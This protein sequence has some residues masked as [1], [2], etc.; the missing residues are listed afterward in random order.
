MS[1][2]VRV[3]PPRPRPWTLKDVLGTLLSFPLLPLL[4]LIVLAIP[5]IQAQTLLMVG[6]PI[7]FK[8]TRKV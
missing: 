8:V 1:M 2:D 5:T 4:T 3:R 6:M 7:Q